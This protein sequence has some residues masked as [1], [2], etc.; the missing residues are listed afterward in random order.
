[1]LPWLPARSSG[2]RP[3]GRASAPRARR[4]GSR[5]PGLRREAGQELVEFALILPLLLLL[6]LGIIEFGR[7]MLAYNTI[8]NAAREGA[9]YGIVDPELAGNARPGQ[10][11]ELTSAA[12]LAQVALPPLV[13]CCEPAGGT[14]QVD[15]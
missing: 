13:N 3:A 6:F 4:A 9:R 15:G 7:A 10:T 11:L 8:A 2:E 1:M 5:W 12:G 14:V